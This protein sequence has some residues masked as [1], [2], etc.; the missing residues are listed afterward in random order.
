MDYTAQ[1]SM[2]GMLAALRAA[3]RQPSNRTTTGSTDGEPDGLVRVLQNEAFLA[4]VLPDDEVV[5]S[6]DGDSTDDLPPLEDDNGEGASRTIHALN[7]P[8]ASTRGEGYDVLALESASTPPPSG[9]M[10]SNPSGNTQTPMQSEASHIPSSPN[11]GSLPARNEDGGESDSSLPTLQTVSDSE[12]EDDSYFDS[13]PDWDESDDFDSTADSDDD[14]HDVPDPATAPAPPTQSRNPLA[15]P[16]PMRLID[17]MQ[18]ESGQ[19]PVDFEDAFQSYRELLERARSTLPDLV[20]GDL[21]Q[22]MDLVENDPRRAEILLGG[23]ETVPESLVCRYELLRTADGEDGDG[24][25]ICRDDLIDKSP[26]PAETA[27]TVSAYAAL[28]FHPDANSIVAFACS[29]KHLFHSD[30]ISPWLAQKTTC[31]SCRFDIDPYSLTHRRSRGSNSLNRP[32]WQP[33]KV[34]SMSEWL[35]A[36][37]RARASG[38]PRERAEVVMP[39]Y[40]TTASSGNDALFAT[41]AGSTPGL[42]IR[43]SPLATS[44]TEV[45]ATTRPEWGFDTDTGNFNLAAVQFDADEMRRRALDA[46]AQRLRLES[47]LY[48]ELLPEAEG[49]PQTTARPPSAPPVY[50][51][52]TSPGLFSSPDP[53]PRFPL[54][55][56][57]PSIFALPSQEHETNPDAP[58]SA[59]RLRSLEADRQSF[60][61]MAYAEMPSDTSI[62][63]GHTEILREQHRAIL[64]N[65]QPPTISLPMPPPPPPLYPDA[66]TRRER[67]EYLHRQLD[68]LELARQH[69][70]AR[71]RTPQP[72]PASTPLQDVGRSVSPVNRDA[73]NSAH[74]FDSVEVP[75][76][77][78]ADLNQTFPVAAPLTLDADYTHALLDS[79]SVESGPGDAP[80][81][82][83]I[84]F[85]WAE[86]L[87]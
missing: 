55:F 22:H 42:P 2:L 19:R 83:G 65:R 39:R 45:L 87:D 61:R 5:R 43:A 79:S 9:T 36:E 80:P 62:P 86:S 32:G 71:I 38:V 28:P 7:T 4:G 75:P 68:I 3:R 84:G 57:Y 12:D 23:L 64:A 35:D 17:L 73:A 40:S 69:H 31:P 8:S 44:P 13:D 51:S 18:H 66:A 58:T 54:S 47:Y 20:L 48:D 67:V 77:I 10:P 16:P 6:E 52:G 53:L 59:E 74:S 25:A 21:V 78:Q 60:A 29:G 46:E 34:Q 50:P 27:E 72:A 37:E 76:M 56:M 1:N 41:T 81:R 33:P 14:H 24:C 11:T 49:A 26:V 70:I 30:C 63:P 15:E 85:H 82:T